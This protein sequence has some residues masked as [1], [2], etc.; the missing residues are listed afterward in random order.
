MKSLPIIAI[1][2]LGAAA[3]CSADQRS[4][5]PPAPAP[6]RTAA[7]TTTPIDNGTTT[8]LTPASGVMVL[9]NYDPPLRVPA[10]R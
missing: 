10:S 9:N 6:T 8:P 2:V 1:A 5:A 3:A 4:A 7:A